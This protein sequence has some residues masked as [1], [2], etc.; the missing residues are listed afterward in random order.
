MPTAWS[1]AR[2]RLVRSR[3]RPTLHTTGVVCT[4]QEMCACFHEHW[5]WMEMSAVEV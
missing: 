2:P 1:I 4:V 3:Y 5:P